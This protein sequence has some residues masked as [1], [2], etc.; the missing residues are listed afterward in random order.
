[1]RILNGRVLLPDGSL[2]EEAVTIQDGIIAAVGGN[3]NGSRALD[4]RGLLVLPGIIDIHG[5]AFEHLMMPRPRALVPRDLA[6]F[7]TDRQL[8]S[9]GITTAFYAMTYTW[10][11]GARSGEAARAFLEALEA[12]RPRL[13]CDSRLHLRFEIWHLPAVE[14]VAGWLASGRV[15]LL[16]FNDHADYT[17]SKFQNPV[18][19]A[20]LADRTGLDPGEYLAMF[21]E[22]CSRRGEVRQ[23]VERLAAVARRAGVPMASHDEETV[24]VREWYHGLGC[25]ICEF[26]CNRETAQAARTLGDPVVLGGPNALKGGSVYDRLSVREAVA[27][28]ICTILSSDYYYPSQLNAAFL[29]ARLGICSFGQ[30]WD[31]VSRHAAVAVGLHDRGEIAA[32]RRADL[33]LVDDAWPER[34]RVV[35]TLVRGRVAYMAGDLLSTGPWEPSPLSLLAPR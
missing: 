29:L 30:A 32:G 12:A 33:I 25:G 24:A 4:A 7:E 27:E 19:L 16:A 13:A 9:N 20:L 35:A 5:D 6:L 15:D 11:P 18:A 1:M 14:G 31:L 10:E 2:V 34:P 26:P 17:A 21:R 22:V 3:G 28:G 23:G 8:V